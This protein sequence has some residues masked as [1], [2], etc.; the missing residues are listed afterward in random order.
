VERANGLGSSGDMGKETGA[1]RGN[2]SLVVGEGGRLPGHKVCIIIYY[3]QR[4]LHDS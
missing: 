1:G 2:S 3:I 4:C